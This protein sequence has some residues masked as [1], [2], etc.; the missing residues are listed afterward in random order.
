MTRRV[1]VALLCAAMVSVAVT[2]CS[3]ARPPLGFPRQPAAPLTGVRLSALVPTPAGFTLNRS[4]SSDSGTRPA[5]PVRGASNTNGISCA[6]WWSGKGYFGPGTVG[7]TI[8]S[9][10]GPSHLTLHIGVNI[11]P[12]GTGAGMYTMS[13]ALQGRCRDF[14]YVDKN[15]VRYAVSA[16]V[17]PSAGIGDHSQEVDA[18]ETAPSGTVFITQTTYVDVGDVLVVATETGAASAPVNRAPLP[19]AAI[20][21]ALR[22]A[23][24]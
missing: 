12:A 13:V 15:G 19:L 14:S 11:Y 10:A 2:G 7:Y 3:A 8:R 23:G 20:A 5:T 9:Y 6:S 16:T 17:G 1:R 22:S 24:Y 18:T 4:A 21:A